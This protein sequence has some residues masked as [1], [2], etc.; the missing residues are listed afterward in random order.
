MDNGFYS[1]EIRSGEQWKTDTT[2]AVMRPVF[3]K[4]VVAPVRVVARASIRI[5][6]F[7]QDIL[8]PEG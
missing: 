8:T 3:S 6:V 5:Q 4:I 1:G 2:P 7:V